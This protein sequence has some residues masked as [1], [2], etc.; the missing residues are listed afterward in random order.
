MKHNSLPEQA[1]QLEARKKQE[2]GLTGVDGKPMIYL[3]QITQKAFELQYGN[4]TVDFKV[5]SGQIIDAH[6]V[7][8]RERLRPY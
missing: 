4:L 8:Q 1:L 7:M 5:K 6:V 2:K 3:D